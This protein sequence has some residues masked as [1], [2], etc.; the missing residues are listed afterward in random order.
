MEWRRF[1]EPLVYAVIDVHLEEHRVVRVTSCLGHGVTR[2]PVVQVCVDN[3]FADGRSATTSD[4]RGAAAGVVVF[5]DEDRD[6]G[7]VG[8]SAIRAMNGARHELRISV[9]YRF[10]VGHWR[11]RR[12]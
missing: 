11:D 7:H 8:K 3:E 2:L 1:E 6:L 9:R 10:T 5:L 12:R 4:L